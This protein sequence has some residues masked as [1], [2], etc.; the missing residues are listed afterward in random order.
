MIWQVLNRLDYAVT[1]PWR[2]NQISAYSS[3]Q[4]IEQLC[5]WAIVSYL[6]EAYLAIF[7]GLT[8]IGPGTNLV[9]YYNTT[10]ADAINLVL[11]DFLVSSFNQPHN[12]RG[13]G[14]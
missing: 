8:S 1:I 10:G 14:L 7:C 6:D 9:E 13:Y 3:R 4:E 5:Q 11:N 2:L 12:P